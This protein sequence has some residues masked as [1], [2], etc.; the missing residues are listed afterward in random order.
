MLILPAVNLAPT[1]FLKCRCRYYIKTEYSFQFEQNNTVV[2]MFGI[3]Y[4][5]FC[6]LITVNTVC[7]YPQTA[8][9]LNRMFLFDDKKG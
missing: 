2:F 4:A 8:K 3:C 6:H 9:N 5:G 1:Q 7:L